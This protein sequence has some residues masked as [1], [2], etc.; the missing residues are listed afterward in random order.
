MDDRS[1]QAQAL[2]YATEL[3][4][5]YAS[6]REQRR[7]AEAAVGQLEASYRTTV[8]ALA[9]AL[10]LRDDDTGAHAQRVAALALRL[11]ER[12]EPELAREPQLE[13]GYL[14][15]D[16]GKIGISDTIVLK[17]GPLDAKQ[18]TE[19]RRH[20]ELGVE[21]LSQVPYLAG[22]AIEVV[23]SHHER[24]DGT[25]YPRGL[26]GDEI[27]SSGRIFAVCDT[28]D[29]MT[30]DRPYRR[31]LPVECALEEIGRQAGTQFDPK[32]A[33]AF[34]ALVHDLHGPALERAS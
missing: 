18:V 3:R 13:Y 32:V 28:F 26:R 19:M 9:S 29:A 11:T 21:L 1:A 22:C 2:R 20:V 33:V 15:H 24:W 16:V 17:P 30:N 10:E 5:L 7:R 31:A 6:E 34:I 14:L 12:V 25:G 8:R 23:A 4:D 27:P